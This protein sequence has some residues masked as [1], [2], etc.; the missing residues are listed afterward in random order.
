MLQIAG[1]Y[2]AAPETAG[3]ARGMKIESRLKIHTFVRDKRR[4]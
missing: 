2:L 4:R 3:K 1:A